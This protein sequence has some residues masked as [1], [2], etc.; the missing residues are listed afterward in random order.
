MNH[1]LNTALFAIEKISEKDLDFLLEAIEQEKKYRLYECKKKRL[2]A[3]VSLMKNSR[4]NC[5]NVQIADNYSMI[6]IVV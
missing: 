5:T 6:N 4:Q 2:K 1:N 3:T